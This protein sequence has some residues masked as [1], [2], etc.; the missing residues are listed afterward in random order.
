MED[1]FGWV[2][3]VEEARQRAVPMTWDD[4]TNV[5]WGDESEA[6]ED[7]A[8]SPPA[9]I[10]QM[11]H[12]DSWPHDTEHEPGVIKCV[13]LY[14]YNVK[15]ES[16]MLVYL[17][18]LLFFLQL[19]AQNPDELTI[20]E[21][22]Q[23]DLLGEGDGDGWVRARNY[24]GEEGYVPQNYVE[25]EGNAVAGYPL[26]PQISFSSVDYHVQ[27]MNQEEGQDENPEG[28]E[29]ANGISNGY[30]ETAEGEEFFNENLP[31]EI[32]IPTAP[33]TVSSGLTTPFINECRGE[34][35]ELNLPKFSSNVSSFLEGNFCRALYDYEATAPE[36][37]SFFEGQIIRITKYVRTLRF[38]TFIKYLKYGFDS[39]LHMTKTMVGGKESMTV[40]VV[41]FR[42]L[43][44]MNVIGMVSLLH[45]R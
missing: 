6:V 3:R 28:M 39:R 34:G 38:Q 18:K 25:T 35:E 2:A 13:A 37:L 5:D 26:Q 15:F 41:Y 31:E 43:C 44:A 23:L 21:N 7:V 10:S 32:P 24:K 30:P 42:L 1:S 17:L 9:E 4:P 36:E 8:R 27:G 14:S 19:Q 16:E 20:L 12:R 45:Q 11:G 40:N 22:E 29:Q 33:T